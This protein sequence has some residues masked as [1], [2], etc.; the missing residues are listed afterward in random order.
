[1]NRLISKRR[2]I[3][4]LIST[5]LAVA[6]LCLGFSPLLIAQEQIAPLNA[7][8]STSP[9]SPTSPEGTPAA[10]EPPPSPPK[11]EISF[12][13]LKYEAGKVAPGSQLRHQF[14]YTNE[15]E[16]PLRL[17]EVG[18]GCSCKLISFDAEIPPGESGVI[19]VELEIYPEWAGQIFTKNIWVLT[20]DPLVPQAALTIT[21]EVTVITPQTP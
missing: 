18:V 3:L 19:D 9:D 13:Y 20:N 8:S 14:H 7:E 6:C 10:N 11:P 12:D 1:M 15:G 5:S 17:T 21:G 2:S 4:T 16:K